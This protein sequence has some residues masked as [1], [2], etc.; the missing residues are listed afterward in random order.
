MILLADRN[1][2][3]YQL[4]NKCAG[5]GTSLLWGIKKSLGLPVLKV[6]SDGSHIAEVKD[7]KD[8]M[9]YLIRL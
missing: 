2:Y 1:F 7:S 6:L 5:S 4:W 3:S 9:H 8:K